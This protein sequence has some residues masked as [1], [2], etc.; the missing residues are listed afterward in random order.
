MRDGILGSLRLFRTSLRDLAVYG[1][2]VGPKGYGCRILMTVMIAFHQD[3]H[4]NC[5]YARAESVQ[6][7][8]KWIEV[9]TTCEETAGEQE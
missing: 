5:I 4:M 9:Y 1:P 2:P 6:D 7:C 8:R 3:T